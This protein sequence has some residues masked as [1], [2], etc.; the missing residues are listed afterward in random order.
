MQEVPEPD[1][2]AAEDR[3]ADH[4][5]LHVDDRDGTLRDHLVSDHGLGAPGGL[6][7]STLGGLHDR[8]HGSSH[9]ADDV[10]G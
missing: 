2:A 1:I 4:D 6:S 9:A 7:P 5:H 10:P 8:L 3:T